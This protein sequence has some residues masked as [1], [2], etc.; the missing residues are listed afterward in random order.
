MFPGRFTRLENLAREGREAGV[1]VVG[2][3]A[4][5][6]VAGLIEGI[7]RQLVQD[8]TARWCVAGVV[9]GSLFAYL[10]LA[11]RARR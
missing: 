6:L 3:V 7:F 2:A 10:S 11:G 4:L 8:L 5:L 9:G 1:L